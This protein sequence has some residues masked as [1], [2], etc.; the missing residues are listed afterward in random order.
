ME[1]GGVADIPEGRAGIQREHPEGRSR[2]NRMKG[3]EMNL[4]KYKKK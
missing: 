1:L 4:K 2:G 3:S